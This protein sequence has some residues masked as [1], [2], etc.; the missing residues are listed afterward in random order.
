MLERILLSALGLVLTAF[1]DCIVD[2]ST[3]EV[4]VEFDAVWH[5][6]LAWYDACT[7]ASA[8]GGRLDVMEFMACISR[9]GPHVHGILSNYAWAYKHAVCIVD[10][11]AIGY[12]APDTV[13]VDQLTGEVLVEFEEWYH[14][15]SAASKLAE[16]APEDKAVSLE[17]FLNVLSESQ[18]ITHGWVHQAVAN[19]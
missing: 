18:P 12:E 13:F 16:L 9:F 4:L 3:G 1:A 11:T 8:S 15:L 10:G 19:L 6:L 17:D 7:R 5:C 14:A 2:D